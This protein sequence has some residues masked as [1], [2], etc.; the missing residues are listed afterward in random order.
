MR[1]VFLFQF[2]L[3][4]GLFLISA[5][6]LHSRLPLANS[7]GKRLQMKRKIDTAQPCSNSLC[8]GLTQDDRVESKTPP[9]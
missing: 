3:L 7:N 1:A 2:N 5:A 6:K 9:A 4:L 8:G